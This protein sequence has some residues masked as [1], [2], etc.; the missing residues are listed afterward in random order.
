MNHTC[1]IYIVRIWHGR[2]GDPAPFRA[3]VRE[4][5]QEDPQV[6]TSGSDVAAFLAAGGQGRN[7]D[8]APARSLAVAGGAR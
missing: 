3:A 2:A 8:A 6:F 1:R 7:D 4:V 5:D